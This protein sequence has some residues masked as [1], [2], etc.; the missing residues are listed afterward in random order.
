[1]G[2]TAPIPL[3]H[4]EVDE[5]G[6]LEIWRDDKSDKKWFEKCQDKSNLQFTPNVLLGIKM[7]NSL[8]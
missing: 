8:F 2:A 4:L 5:L 3:H 6:K 7:D 1:M